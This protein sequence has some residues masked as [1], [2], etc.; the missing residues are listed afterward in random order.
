VNFKGG[1]MRN[2]ITREVNVLVGIPC[3]K[4]DS[5]IEIVKQCDEIFV[6][7]YKYIEVDDN[8]KSNIVL[9]AALDSSKCEQTLSRDST[10]KL[11]N[12]ILV[13]PN[14]IIE[15][16]GNEEDMDLVETSCNLGIVKQESNHIFLCSFIRSFIETRKLYLVE[17]MKSLAKLI[18]A[19]FTTS[20][21]SP[22][23]E[24]EE[25]SEL[26]KLFINAYINAF[27]VEPKVQS[28]HAGLECGYFA[29]KFPEMDMISCG[30]TLQSVHTPDEIMYTDTIIKVTELLLLVLYQMKE[31]I[32]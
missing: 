29:K 15:M 21:D 11:I 23:W 16:F 9:T 31:G 12:T 17:Q 2:A 26:K 32:D 14:G 19:E 4:I 13:I 22:N 25:K 24:P 18:N 8:G 10:S 3:E 30:P 1:T 28:V 5:V 27:D 7:E 6:H 20:C